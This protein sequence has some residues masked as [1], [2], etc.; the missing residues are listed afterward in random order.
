MDKY[1]LILADIKLIL[2]TI[3]IVN[4]V[5]HGKVIPLVTE[6]TFTSV[7]IKPEVDNFDI[8]IA[9]TSASS[10]MNTFYVRLEVNMD[11]SY[12]LEW[13]NIR[14]LVIDAI[15]DDEAIWTNI[16]DRDIISIA[17]DDYD[18]YPKKTMALLFA[19]K[20]REDCVV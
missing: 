7:Y 5:S 11:C 20:I 15:L 17:H 3:G 10:Y 16:V 1:E 18:N 12:D 9:G 6:D 4:K 8:H 19:F 2:E 14:R 13:V